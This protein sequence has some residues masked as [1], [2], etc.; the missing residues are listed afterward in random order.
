MPWS[1]P[2][3]KRPAANYGVHESEV[4]LYDRKYRVVVVHS[5]A[6]DKRRKKRIEREIAEGRVELEQEVQKAVKVK[7][8]CLPDAQEAGKRLEKLQGKYHCIRTEVKE[9]VKYARGRPSKGKQRKIAQIQYEVEVV[10]EEKER[11]AEKKREEAGCF[12]LLRNV[13]LKKEREHRV[14]SRC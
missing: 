6:H 8:Y 2:I 13:E 4:R 5:D 10:I 14:P 3:K 9:V 7:Y 1:P 11:A 12:V